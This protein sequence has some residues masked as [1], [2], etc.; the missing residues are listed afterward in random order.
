MSMTETREHIPGCNMAFYKWALVG[1]GGLD[2]FLK[3]PGMM[4]TFAG[5]CNSG[6]EHWL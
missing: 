5:G 4:W 2:P 3:G 1:L 6:L